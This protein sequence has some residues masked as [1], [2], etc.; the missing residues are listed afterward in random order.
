MIILLVYLMDILGTIRFLLLLLLAIIPLIVIV[1]WANNLELFEEF[2]KHFKKFVFIY[3]LSL[4]VFTL[5][6][7]NKT[8][9][10]MLGA[11]VGQVGIQ[12]FKN[13]DIGSKALLLLEQKLDEA[14]KND[15]KETK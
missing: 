4:A 6:P 15:T 5:I 1:S 7:S 2:K 3:F 13:S 14:L 10:L 9:M 12:T 8:R 11:Y